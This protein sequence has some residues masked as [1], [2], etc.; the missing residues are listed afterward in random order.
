MQG[1]LQVSWSCSDE[2]EFTELFL[3]CGLAGLR[4]EVAGRQEAMGCRLYCESMTK[5]FPGM[6]QRFHIPLSGSREMMV[7][8]FTKLGGLRIF[9]RL[10]KQGLG[11]QVW[12]QP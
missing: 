2:L 8:G 9:C 3:S 7:S 1:F 11:G 6:I 4:L 12:E 10:I 5:K